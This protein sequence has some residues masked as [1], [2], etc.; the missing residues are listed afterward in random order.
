MSK[1]RQVLRALALDFMLDFLLSAP[2]VFP[3]RK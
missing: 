1:S 3:Q 2:L